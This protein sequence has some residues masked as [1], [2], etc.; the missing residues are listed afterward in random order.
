MQASIQRILVATDYSPA[1]K[2]AL[3]FACT[4]A[5]KFGAE[6]HL[7]H[8]VVEPTPM[9]VPEGVWLERETIVPALARNA[10]IALTENTKG[11]QLEPNVQV[12][13]EV[14]IGYPSDEIQRYAVEQK[15]DLIVIG[16]QGH[17]GLSRILLG[18][19]AEKTVR[20]AKCPVMTIHAPQPEKNKAGASS[21]LTFQ[22]ILVATD[23]SPPAG[24]AR[25]LGWTL[26]S[27]YGAEL[28]LLNIVV[29]PLPLPGPH[30]TWIRPEDAT[31]AYVDSALRSLAEE[32]KEAELEPGLVVVRAVKVGYPVEAIQQYVADHQIDL[33]VLGTQGHGG[34]SHLLLGSIA[35][36]IVRL[37]TCPVLTTH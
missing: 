3:D 21:F 33:I 10:K 19:V 4:I 7:L 17:R 2:L 26:A 24:R 20:I 28:H 30:G 15:V 18:S 29:E 36:K 34:L 35:E 14:K 25:D 37:A 13:R 11:L 12:I 32:A 27:K 6:L 1:A 9:V 23:F 16:T 8:V 5:N 22:R 31:P